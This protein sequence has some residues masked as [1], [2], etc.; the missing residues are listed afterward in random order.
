MFFTQ[1]TRALAVAV[2]IFLVS[3]DFLWRLCPLCRGRL[4]GQR[5]VR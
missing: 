3:F 4:F 1:Y 2:R 5:S